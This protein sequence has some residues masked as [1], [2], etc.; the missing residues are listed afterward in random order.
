GE[1]FDDTPRQLHAYPHEHSGRK[2]HALAKKNSGRKGLVRSPD[3]A[4]CGDDARAAAASSRA[5]TSAVECPYS[6]SRSERCG[7][8]W[9]TADESVADAAVRDG[10]DLQD[11]RLV[12]ERR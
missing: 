8:P 1:S 3:A 7:S 4:R 9:S 2:F 11:H 12:I 10:P 5:C 6:Y